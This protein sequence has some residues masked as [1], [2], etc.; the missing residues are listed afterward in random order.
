[1]RGALTSKNPENVLNDS[2][3]INGIK[4][5]VFKIKSP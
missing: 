5:P 3:M 1:M 4:K 2:N